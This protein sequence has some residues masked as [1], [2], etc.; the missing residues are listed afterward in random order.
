MALAPPA[1]K[2]RRLLMDAEP[3]ALD[4]GPEIS[5]LDD[6][7]HQI[8]SACSSPMPEYGTPKSQ[9]KFSFS[10]DLKENAKTPEAELKSP[11]S[12]LNPPSSLKRR[13]IRDYFVAAS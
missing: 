8:S 1:L 10:L 6:Q 2:R 9:E 4:R 5:A 12:V 11:S 13:T 3:V 7:L